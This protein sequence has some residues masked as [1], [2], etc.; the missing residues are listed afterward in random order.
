MAPKLKDG[1]RQRLE[2]MLIRSEDDTPE[3]D[4]NAMAHCPRCGRQADFDEV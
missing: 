2:A 4:E 3:Y 1:L